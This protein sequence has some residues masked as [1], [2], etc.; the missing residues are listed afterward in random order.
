MT[1]WAEGEVAEALAGA[2]LGVAS[3]IE[4]RPGCADRLRAAVIERIGGRERD[5]IRRLA[6]EIPAD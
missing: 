4:H 6:E 1:S 2:L 3:L 5:L